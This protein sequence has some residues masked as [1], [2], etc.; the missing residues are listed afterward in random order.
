MQS[1]PTP[2]TARR[3][4]RAVSDVM[5]A[6]VLVAVL[7]VGTAAVGGVL[8]GLTDALDAKPPVGVDVDADESSDEIRVSFVADQGGDTVVSVSVTDAASGT[9]VLD[10]SLTSVG[11]SVTATGVDG[12]R[13]DVLVTGS[14]G[15]SSWIVVEKTITV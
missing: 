3:T 9:V 12:H 1:P 2:R 6:M 13:Y 5:A 14:A 11:E 10:E 4:D 7:A 8:L 15:D